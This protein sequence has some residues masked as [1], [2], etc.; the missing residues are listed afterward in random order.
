MLHQLSKDKFAL[1]T[2]AVKEIQRL[3]DEEGYSYME[4]AIEYSKRIELDVE[5]VAAIIKKV[6]YLEAKIQEEAEGLNLLPKTDR[7]PF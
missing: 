1:Q 4:A 7:L 6:P 2:M 3:V 5:T